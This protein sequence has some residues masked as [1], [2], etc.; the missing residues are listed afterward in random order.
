MILVESID[1]GAR[2]GTLVLGS[3]PWPLRDARVAAMSA[4]AV[5]LGL[6]VLQVRAPN[7]T[8][9]DLA[10]DASSPTAAGALQRPWALHE[11]EASRTAQGVR[12]RARIA[13]RA[14]VYRGIL[15]YTDLVLR[16]AAVPAADVGLLRLVTY[17]LCVNAVEH[18][19]PLEP[20]PALEIGFE[21]EPAAVRGWVRDGCA[22]FDPVQFQP[23]AVSRLLRDQSRRGYGLRIVHRVVD[24]LVHAHDG[25]GNTVEFIR[26]LSHETAS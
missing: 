10:L 15:A 19:R 22:C 12:Y 16:A 1:I 25:R 23:E 11:H 5:D 4:A 8:S 3:V 26:E 14:E 24:S 18:G 6:H 17:E 7:G 2:R 20:A 21:I 9:S 13:H